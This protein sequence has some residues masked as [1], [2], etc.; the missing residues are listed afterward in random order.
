MA[1]T[2]LSLIMLHIIA[3]TQVQVHQK[4]SKYQYLLENAKMVSL[5]LLPANVS[6]VRKALICWNIQLNPLLAKNVKLRNLTVMAETWF[7]QSLTIG[8]AAFTVIISS[9]AETIL[10]AWA[11]ILQKII[12]LELARLGTWA[13]YVQIVK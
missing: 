2:I 7:T 6:T 10:H 12:L 4:T 8:E 9:S 5:Y 13:F 11:K 3:Q 1:L